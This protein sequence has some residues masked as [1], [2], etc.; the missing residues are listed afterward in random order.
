MQKLPEKPPASWGKDLSLG[1]EKFA[2]D[3]SLHKDV[4]EYNRRYLYW[5]E[6]KYRIEDPDRRK[7]IWALMKFLR[8]MRFEHVTVAKIDLK[9]SFIPDIVKDC[10]LSIGTS[11]AQYRST[12][13]P[14]VWNNRISSTP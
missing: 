6:L 14:S 1:D 7:A 5:D 9:Y 12:T 8:I 13:R 3:D 2:K 11:P 10:I 4:W